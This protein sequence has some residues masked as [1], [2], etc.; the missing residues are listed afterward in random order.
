MRPVLAQD[1]QPE[2]VEWLWRNRIPKGMI[3]IVAGRPAQGKG[4]F[5]AHVA[6]EVSRRGMNVLYSAVEDSDALMTRPRLEAA[7]AD[8]SRIFLANFR[9]PAQQDELEAVVVE[10]NIGLIVIDPMASHLSRGIARHS[11]S[12][13]EV[14]DPLKRMATRTGVSILIVEHVN[15]RVAK[16]SD[17]LAAI[18]GGGSGIVAAAR[19]AFI[20]GVDPE[21]GDRRIL[22][23]V[24]LNITEKP[25][26]V[27]FE[28]ESRHFR[29]CG[30]V[31][32]LLYDDEFDFSAGRLFEETK[33]GQIGRPADKRAQAS[34]WLTAYLAS[35]G[36]PVPA[37]VVQED[38][39]Q[40]GMTTKTLRRAATDME[41][42]R[43][44]AGGGPNCTW[45]LPEDVKTAMGLGQADDDWDA[46]LADLLGGDD[47]ET[48]TS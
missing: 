30:E 16:G 29:G 14:S 8:L 32:S 9:L 1:V 38:A 4:L 19:A 40:N 13:R 22:A 11:D 44:P 25:K 10:H 26:A 24:K 21:D 35:A 33:D 6:A 48:E 5:T 36:G 18:G 3:S 27:G 15:K 41:I 2:R 7:G 39:R 46:G 31:P 34:E 37:G 45:D 43:N 42:V 12:I 47:D 20:L 23:C 17:P 28:I